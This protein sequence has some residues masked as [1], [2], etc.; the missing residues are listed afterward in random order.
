MCGKKKK[1]KVKKIK[2][3]MISLLIFFKNI[4]VKCKNTILTLTRIFASIPIR[5]FLLAT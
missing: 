1:I 4:V 3:K 2:N 5:H